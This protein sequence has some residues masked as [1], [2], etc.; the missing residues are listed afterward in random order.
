MFSGAVFPYTRMET[1]TDYFVYLIIPV[2]LK[3]IN[4]DYLID[5]FTFYYYE[6]SF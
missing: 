3:T 4:F 5:S 1:S 2:E 6:F